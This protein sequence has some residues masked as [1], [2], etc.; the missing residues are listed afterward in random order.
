MTRENYEARKGFLQSLAYVK[1]MQSVNAKISNYQI[2]DLNLLQNIRENV[3][4]NLMS[5]KII[6]W[7]IL[8]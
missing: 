1:I 3:K 4:Q 2:T 8:K 7:R 6:R 5:Q